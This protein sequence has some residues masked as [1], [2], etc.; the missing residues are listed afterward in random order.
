ML[1]EIAIWLGC[2]ALISSAV[3]YGLGRIVHKHGP[4]DH[5]PDELPPAAEHSASGIH[6]RVP[7][8]YAELADMYHALSTRA[9]TLAAAV[10]V[11]CIHLGRAGLHEQA[12]ELRRWAGCGEEKA[13]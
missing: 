1:G 3:A 4:K 7:P 11:A 10:D 9:A 5:E 6:A 12:N 2:A 8:T 13:S